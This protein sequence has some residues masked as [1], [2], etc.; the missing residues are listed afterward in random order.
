M[1]ITVDYLVFL[2][3]TRFGKLYLSESFKKLLNANLQDNQ[4]FTDLL[5]YASA[6]SQFH[7]HVVYGRMKN[8]TRKSALDLFWD[9]DLTYWCKSHNPVN[10]N[11]FCIHHRCRPFSM[12]NTNVKLNFACFTSEDAPPC[13]I[14]FTF[15]PLYIKVMLLMFRS[16]SR[17]PS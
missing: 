7:L 16:Q 15:S 9:K 17:K 3:S 1:C 8:V 4:G 2:R 14:S 5:R 13:F 10:V 6:F 12:S 11:Y